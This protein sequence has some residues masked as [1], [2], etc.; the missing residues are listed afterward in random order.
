MGGVLMIF[1]YLIPISYRIFITYSSEMTFKTKNRKLK[2]NERK[3][4]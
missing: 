2:K 1:I 4:L 3:I